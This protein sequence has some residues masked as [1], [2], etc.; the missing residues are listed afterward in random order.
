VGVNVGVSVGVLVAVKV[1]VGVFEAVGVGPGVEVYVAVDVK[2]MV[3]DDVGEEVGEEVGVNVL[4]AVGVGVKKG[5][6]GTGVFG[7]TPPPGVPRI[8]TSLIIVRA[9]SEFMLKE[10]IKPKIGWYC[11]TA[12][13]I[14]RSPSFTSPG[15]GQMLE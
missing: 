3:G 8:T 7:A 9:V 12:R 13:T 6:G 2:V 14:T 4:V 11:A 5:V 10:G 15:A 1:G